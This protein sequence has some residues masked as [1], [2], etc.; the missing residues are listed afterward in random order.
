MIQTQ[1]YGS[2][3]QDVLESE[4][5][6]YDTEMKRVQLN[7]AE[8]IFIDGKKFRLSSNG[9]DSLR[10]LVKV[11]KAFHGRM[12]RYL[13][14]GAQIGLI[15]ALRKGISRSNKD[16]SVMTAID[17]SSGKVISV[18]KAAPR[19]SFGGYFDLLERMM[20]RYNLDLRTF[21]Y[22]NGSGE[23]RVGTQ[24]NN[25][26]YA[27]KD[28]EDEVFKAGPMFVNELGEL[29]VHSFMQRLICTNG[30]MAIREN[31]DFTA[32]LNRE[33]MTGFFEYI[34]DLA[35]HHFV[36]TDFRA[37]VERAMRTPASIREAERVRETIQRH[38]I[39]D[40]NEYTEWFVPMNEIRSAYSNVGENVSEMSI[41]QKKNAPTN[42]NVWELVNALTDFASHDQSGRDFDFDESD[43][44]VMIAS[45]GKILGKKTF[46]AENLVRVPNFRMN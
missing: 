40:D 33:D 34:D 4:P 45:A 28:Y 16:M 32:K 44:N 1:D 8:S 17:R 6:F 11:P 38:S 20:D 21:S 5:L 30:L 41:T 7:D 35:E 27:L 2:F 3:K 31:Q 13:G 43:S 42:M 12:E 37:R 19:L 9:L 36:P 39:K 22:D 18:Q 26:Q 46:D 15:D 14:S 23:L 10:S 25:K 24:A 29:Q